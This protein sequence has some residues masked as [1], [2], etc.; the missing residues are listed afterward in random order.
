MNYIRLCKGIADKGKL[1][2]VTDNIYN[3]VDLNKDY[4]VSAFLYDEEHYNKFKKE[5]TVSGITNTVTSK[6]YWD[7]DS[8]SN[9]DQA[10]T[11]AL[12]LCDRLFKKGFSKSEVS[13]FFSGKKGFQVEVN[14]KKETFTPTEVKN[15]CLSLGKNLT[16][17]DRQIYNSNRILRL[18]LTK[19]QDTGLYKI[20]LDP[21]D[22]IEADV[23]AIKEAASDTYK[24]EDR[25]EERRVGKECRSR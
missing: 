8:E 24:V 16:T 12:E 19:H 23:S 11:D 21:D 22:I 1:I 2:P 6:L 3:G 5:G 18:P 20:P 9:L 14:F 25:S 4:Y 17:L 7:F 15:I 10:K 13:L